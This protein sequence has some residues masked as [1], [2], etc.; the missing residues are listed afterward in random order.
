M[1]TFF[2]SHSFDD[3]S[4]LFSHC[5]L[6]KECSRLQLA[7]LNELLFSVV[8]FR[9]LKPLLAQ[10]CLRTQPP[11][12]YVI[13]HLQSYWAK[14]RNKNDFKILGSI[15]MERNLCVTTAYV[16]RRK[17]L[18]AISSTKTHLVCFKDSK[19]KR[20]I[21]ENALK[22]KDFA[23]RTSSFTFCIAAPSKQRR[24]TFIRTSSGLTR[25]QIP[26]QVFEAV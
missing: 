3:E 10:K 14:K 5:K 4:Q 15:K 22:K 12:G 21:L 8:Q 16:F 24:W 1:H 20:S 19:S 18:L 23:F 11:L 25:P 26:N 9:C 13:Q 2:V 17:T 6:Q 7:A